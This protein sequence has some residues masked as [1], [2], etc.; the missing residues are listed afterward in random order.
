MHAELDGEEWVRRLMSGAIELRPPSGWRA[1]HAQLWRF[2]WYRWLRGVCT[3]LAPAP[4]PEPRSVELP[5]MGGMRLCLWEECAYATTGIKIPG[6]NINLLM[7]PT[8]NR[9]VGVQIWD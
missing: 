3:Y 7:H 9:V 5:M 1:V 2:G 4:L 8:C 6:T